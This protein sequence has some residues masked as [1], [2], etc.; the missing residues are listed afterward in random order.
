MNGIFTQYLLPSEISPLEEKD[1]CGSWL[2]EFSSE[3]L[4]TSWLSI[5]ET[6][7]RVV[8]S[9]MESQK[10]INFETVHKLDTL[11]LC[12]NI[13]F[14]EAYTTTHYAEFLAD[15]FCPPNEWIIQDLNELNK[16]VM[17]PYQFQFLSNNQQQIMLNLIEKNFIDPNDE[18][19]WTDEPFPWTLY[20]PSISLEDINNWGKMKRS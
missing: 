7:I 12:Q 3:K 9:N 5:Y 11:F 15:G 4:I 13:G 20:L 6:L 8:H 18:L 10:V 14:N 2:L 19:K 17:K 16:V 1:I